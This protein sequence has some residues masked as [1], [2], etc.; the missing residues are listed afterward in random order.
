MV[1]SGRWLLGVIM[2]GLSLF[3]ASCAPIDG[4]TPIPTQVL[5]PA[6]AT[7]TPLP[8]TPTITSTSLPAPA[9]VF[10]TATSVAAL[11]VFDVPINPALVQQA[12]TH[13]A[14]TLVVDTAVIQVVHVESAQW[15]DGT[16]GCS[17]SRPPRLQRAI[18]GFAIIL[19]VGRMQYG[20]HTDT[21]D[22]V[23]A[24]G[25]GEVL[26]GEILL[27]LDPVGTELFGLAQRRV[28]QELDLPVR[29]IRLVDIRPVIWTDSSMGCPREGQTYSD[30]TIDGYRIEVAV[31]DTSYI[32][33]TDADRLVACDPENEQL[34]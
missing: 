28:G 6:T 10:A 22:Q 31:G 14:T 27:S 34:P 4:V 32:F 11:Q 12:V 21:V 2:G 8:I 15:L 5:I 16:L 19:V 13:L 23:R 7:F 20:Y 24:C 25:R 1:V 29:R 18:E 30:I 17:E 33:H 9:D 26:N 3:A